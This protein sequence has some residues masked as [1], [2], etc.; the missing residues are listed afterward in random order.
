MIFRK[1]RH[2]IYHEPNVLESVAQYHHLFRLPILSSPTLP[3]T[4]RYELQVSLLK[5]EMQELKCAIV[6][7]T[8][9][10]VPAA[11]AFANLQYAIGRAVLE[12]GKYPL[13]HSS[14]S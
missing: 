9:D 11:T 3:S 1:R 4:E 6:E 13:V 8:S 10:L 12:F 2:A 14:C 7:S 5:E